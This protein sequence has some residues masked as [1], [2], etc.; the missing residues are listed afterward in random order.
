VKASLVALLCL[1]SL[2]A[3]EP[4]I[5][6]NFNAWLVYFGNHQI[7]NK[8]SLR[9]EGQLRREG[10]LN[11]WQQ[12]L[13]RFGP[14]YNLNS[15]FEITNG[16]FYIQSYPYGDFPSP[17]RFPEHR[18]YQDLWIRL[19]IRKVQFEQRYRQEYRWIG[20]KLSPDVPISDWEYRTRF[21]MFYRVTTPSPWK[22]IYFSVNTEPF[23]TGVGRRRTALEQYRINGAVGFRL[24]SDHRIEI[25]YLRQLLQRPTGVNEHNHTIQIQFY[26]RTPLHA[27][28][29][30]REKKMTASAQ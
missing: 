20:R 7:H 4:I 1:L 21:R 19:P 17:A 15:I 24:D 6:D 3:Q 23:I 13:I 22:L 27:L 8:W 26:S 5:D 28:W 2:Q 10:P 18:F 25:G 30:K 14:S 12:Q 9:L 11:R 16:Y 29:R